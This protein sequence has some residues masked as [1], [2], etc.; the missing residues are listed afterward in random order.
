M[1]RQLTT[2]EWVL[3]GLLAVI[4]LV[5]GYVLLFY[6]PMTTARD[7][8][9]ADTETYR[10]QLKAV[11]LRAEEKRRM[12]RELE[13]I[14]SQNPNATGLAAY[15][16]LQAVMFELHAILAAAEEYSL[17]FGTVNT[18]EEIVRRSIS[19]EFTCGSYDSARAILQQLHDSAYRCML[20]NLNI[21]MGRSTGTVSVNGTIVFFEYQ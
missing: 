2:R 20:E 13:D 17:S 12:E 4:A 8:A 3:L 7:A 18:G 14:F 15:D 6:Q 11:E 10:L 16:N 1:R 5:G 21:S 19:L 9:L